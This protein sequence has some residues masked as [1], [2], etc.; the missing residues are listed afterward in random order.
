[1][2]PSLIFYYFWVL[3]NHATSSCAAQTFE[4]WKMTA[5]EGCCTLCTCSMLIWFGLEGERGN[6]WL[7]DQQHGTG[8]SPPPQPPP[9]RSTTV[10]LVRRTDVNHETKSCSHCWPMATGTGLVGNIYSSLPQT[11]Y[12]CGHR[13]YTHSCIWVP[14]Y[15]WGKIDLDNDQI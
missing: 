3:L 11:I 5:F 9:A 2:L 6:S 4:N 10:V 14:V 12:I 7:I 1:M 13:Q 15:V 8:Y